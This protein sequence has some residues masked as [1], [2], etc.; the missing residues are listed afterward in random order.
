MR[1]LESKRKNWRSRN[2][3]NGTLL[4]KRPSFT[5]LMKIA[6]KNLLLSFKLKFRADRILTEIRKLPKKLK[7]M[8]KRQQTDQQ[9]RKLTLKI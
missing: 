9:L 7:F 4:T 3:Q 6:S 8:L 1:S 5:D 2:K